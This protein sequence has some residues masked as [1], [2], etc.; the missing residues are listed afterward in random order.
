MDK[1]YKPAWWPCNFC[2]LNFKYDEY[3]FSIF[4]KRNYKDTRIYMQRNVGWIPSSE[5]TLYINDDRFRVA[6]LLILKDHQNH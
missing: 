4:I 3:L 2:K 5:N 1:K 6:I